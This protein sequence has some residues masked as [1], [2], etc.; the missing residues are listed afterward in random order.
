MKEK[1]NKESIGM[2]N[3]I[4]YIIMSETTIKKDLKWLI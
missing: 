1:C 3:F 2:I 4:N